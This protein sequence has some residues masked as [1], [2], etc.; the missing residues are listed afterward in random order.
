MS[1]PVVPDFD[2]PD[3]YEVIASLVPVATR[4]DAYALA[5]VRRGEEH[6]LGSFAL[7]PGDSVAEASAMSKVTK[8]EAGSA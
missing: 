3:L 1:S 7:I 8:R 2:G 4:P 5:S 6:S